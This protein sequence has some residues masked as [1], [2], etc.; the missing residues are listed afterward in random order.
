MNLKSACIIAML[1]TLSEIALIVIGNGLFY[2]TWLFEHFHVSIL[3]NA[4]V[5]VLLALFKSGGLILMLMAV[6]IRCGKPDAHIKS[7]FLLAA[8]LIMIAAL[9]SIT[10]GVYYMAIA[11]M[12]LPLAQSALYTSMNL[13]VFL[14]S[15]FLGML[16]L[17]LRNSTRSCKSFAAVTLILCMTLL[18]LVMISTIINKHS[19]FNDDSL[20]RTI[21]S[22]SI[23]ASYYVDLIA[24]I[25]FL[26]M[27]LKYRP[28]SPGGCVAETSSGP[29]EPL[30][31]HADL[32][33]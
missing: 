4:L 18:G 9:I 31:V 6:L 23:T 33:E 21:G 8:I 28:W 11:F 10:T 25:F 29:L 20:L 27:F 32:P 2:A 12:H 26:L 3:V 17:A 7:L 5:P 14:S 19:V 13:L 16:A 22:V 24:Q 1:M 15:L 30:A